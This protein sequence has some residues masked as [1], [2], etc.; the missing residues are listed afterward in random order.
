MLRIFGRGAEEWQYLAARGFEVELVPGISSALSV[1]SLAGVPPTF[2]GV[3]SGF[4]VVTGHIR[5]GFN[6]DLARYAA[7]WAGVS[8]DGALAPASCGKKLTMRPGSRFATLI[9]WALN[10]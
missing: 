2:R 1:P 4:A 10:T 6:E 7:V 5:E 9:P 3:A 8:E